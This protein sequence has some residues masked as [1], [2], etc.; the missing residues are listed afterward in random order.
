MSPILGTLASQFSGK[1]FAVESFESISTATVG[2]GGTSTIS[3]SSIPQ[4]YKH[5]QIRWLSKSNFSGSSNIINT[6]CRFNGDTGNNYSWHYLNGDAGTLTAGGI[7]DTYSIFL[8]YLPAS[9]Y[10]NMFG[11][12]VCDILDY[13][14]SNTYKTVRTFGGCD[15]NNTGGEK[16]IV[17]LATGNWRSFSAISSITIGNASDLSNGFNQYTEFALYGIKG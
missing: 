3:F 11:I 14:N 2:S 5:L 17:S 16:G 15:V 4:T 12:G 7:A 13:T 8:S 9:G 1:P 6:H 10:A